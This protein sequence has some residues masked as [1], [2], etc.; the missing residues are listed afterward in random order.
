V[1]SVL[2]AAWLVFGVPFRGSLGLLLAGST[3]Y[4]LVG[5][6]LG[7]LIAALTRTQLAAMLAALGGTMLPSTLLSGM[8]FPINSMPLP[9]Q[10]LSNLVPARWFVEISR[11]VMLKG[12]GIAELWLQFGVLTLMFVAMMSLAIRKFSVRLD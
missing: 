3:L 6:S 9:L 1:V 12:A 5:L 8:I 4:S 11:G 7:V 10:V 2:V